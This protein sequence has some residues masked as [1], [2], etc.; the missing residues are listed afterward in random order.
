MLARGCWVWLSGCAFGLLLATLTN[1]V[2]L[3]WFRTSGTWL[4]VVI[5]FGV[6]VGALVMAL[7]GAFEDDVQD[8]TAQW[9]GAKRGLRVVREEE[10]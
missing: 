2:A 5:F 3:G 6:C 1:A 8:A 9:T 4:C 7:R 10:R